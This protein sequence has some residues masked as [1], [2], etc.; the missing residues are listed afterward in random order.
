MATFNDFL[1]SSY[2]MIKKNYNSDLAYLRID[3]LE[4]YSIS[5]M[6]LDVLENLEGKLKINKKKI[7]FQYKYLK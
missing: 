2:L 7:L 5:M 6:F 3:L 4:F 1:F